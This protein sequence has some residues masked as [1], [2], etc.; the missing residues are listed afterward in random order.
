MPDL[1]PIIA[2][3]ETYSLA[4][5]A[6]GRRASLDDMVVKFAGWLEEAQDRLSEDDMAVL[7]EVGAIMYRDG[8]RRRMGG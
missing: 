8:L 3:F 2:L 5:C 6:T 1:H 4:I 7:L